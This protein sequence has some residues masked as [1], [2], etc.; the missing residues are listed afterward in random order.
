MLD[1]QKTFE[2]QELLRRMHELNAQIAQ[3]ER[4]LWEGEARL[5]VEG[6]V[7]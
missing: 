5:P 3:L 7:L 1:P 4:S 6:Q 2:R